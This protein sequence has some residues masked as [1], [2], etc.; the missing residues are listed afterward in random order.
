MALTK[1]TADVIQDSTITALGQFVNPDGTFDTV[2][3]SLI[4]SNYMSAATSITEALL[5]LDTNLNANNK[6]STKMERFAFVLPSLVW[7]VTHG[8]NSTMIDTVIRDANNDL[9][10]A[11]VTIIDANTVQVEFTEAQS[12]ELILQYVPN[13]VIIPTRIIPPVIGG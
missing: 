4:T 13:S 9:M 10:F 8:F 6:G 12:G 5:L 2:D 11:P 7:V 1:I 3:N